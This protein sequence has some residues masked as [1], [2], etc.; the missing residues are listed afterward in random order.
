MTTQCHS[1][2]KKKPS[3]IFVGI[4]GKAGHAERFFKQAPKSY[5]FPLYSAISSRFVFRRGVFGLSLFCFCFLNEV[6]LGSS[7]T[8]I[9]SLLYMK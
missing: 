6:R 4:K 5:S 2:N 3:I 9:F 8:V 7:I 1:K